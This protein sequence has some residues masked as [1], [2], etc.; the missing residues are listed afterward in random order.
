MG[1]FLAFYYRILSVHPNIS[2]FCVCVFFFF[3]MKI[4]IDSFIHSCK[5]KGQRPFRQ[6]CVSR[7]RRHGPFPNCLRSTPITATGNTTRVGVNT[8]VVAC[9]HQYIRR[10]AAIRDSDS[11]IKV[12]THTSCKVD[13]VQ[14]LPQTENYKPSHEKY[15]A[16]P[17]NR[18]IITPLKVD[19][20]RDCEPIG[21]LSY[22]YKLEVWYS[23]PA[24]L[25]IYCWSFATQG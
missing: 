22:I 13:V 24:G 15:R 9:P 21:W 4:S 20:D 8:P 25:G 18:K 14:Y 3:A 23:S 19:F 11:S 2:A 1:S 7:C 17:L 6:Q 5:K 16:W 12:P 10:I